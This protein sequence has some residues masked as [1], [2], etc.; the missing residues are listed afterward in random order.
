MTTEQTQGFSDQMLSFLEGLQREMEEFRLQAALGKKDAADRFETLKKEY[1]AVV[2]EALELVEKG[3]AVLGSRADRI[4]GTLDGLAVQLA[5]GRAEAV[6]AY[7]RQK[8]VIT[9]AVESAEQIMNWEELENPLTGR[10]LRH[11]LERLKVNLELI[12]LSYELKRL[13]EEEV[14]RGRIVGVLEHW[15]EKIGGRKKEWDDRA[16]K[17]MEEVQHVYDHLRKS[18]SQL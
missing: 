15:K 14:W 4:R 12:Q 13:D 3:R 16:E 5:L 18:V 8:K 17:V 6:D 7:E 9:E 1:K 10:P 11:D 2:S